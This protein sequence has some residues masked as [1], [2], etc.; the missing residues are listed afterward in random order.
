MP[1]TGNRFPG[2][3]KVM[4]IRLLLDGHNFSRASESVREYLA[5]YGGGHA[6]HGGPVVSFDTAKTVLM[7]AYLYDK[8][9]EEDYL[10]FGGMGLTAGETAVVSEP[11]EGIIAVMGI[12]EEVWALVGQELFVGRYTG[13]RQEELEAG[14]RTMSSLHGFGNGVHEAGTPERFEG[15]ECMEGLLK[16]VR[17]TS[18][19]LEIATGRKRDVNIFLT[20]K[21]AYVAVWEKGLRMAEVLPDAS[22]DSL[23]YYMQVIGRQF[24]LRKF[25]INIGGEHAGVTANSLRQ[26]FSNVRIEA[27]WF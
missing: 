23:L 21:N 16:E 6:A 13:V 9:V 19:L 12:S 27:G 20:D 15:G 24:K 17:T 7:P 5:D 11:R 26:Y 25:D 18:P 22:V 10:R 3:D 2:N 14:N 8:G 4:S 1:E